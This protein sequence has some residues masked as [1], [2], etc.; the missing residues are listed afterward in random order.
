MT[1]KKK[2]NDIK[3][4]NTDGSTCSWNQCYTL[5]HD[6]KEMTKTYPK[7]LSEDRSVPVEKLQIFHRCS[8]CNRKVYSQKDKSKTISNYVAAIGGGDDLI[9]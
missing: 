2:K 9:E 5:F 7:W 3:F 6:D 4:V 8:K 1:L